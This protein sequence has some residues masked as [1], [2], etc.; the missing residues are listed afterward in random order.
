MTDTT[1]ETLTTAWTQIAASTDAAFTVQVRGAYEVEFIFADS[2][3]AESDVGLL[4]GRGQGLTRDHGAG[5]LY[6]R[7]DTAFTSSVVIV[8]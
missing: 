2:L 7:G 8:L 4:L 6:A 3:P 5:N 1:V